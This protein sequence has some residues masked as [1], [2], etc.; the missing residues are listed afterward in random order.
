MSVGAGSL[1]IDRAGL[2]ELFLA[3]TRCGYIL[4]GPTVIPIAIGMTV[5]MRKAVVR[6]SRSRSG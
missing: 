3:L 5:K 4:V 6:R 2:D 1:A